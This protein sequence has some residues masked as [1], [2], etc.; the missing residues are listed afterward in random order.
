MVGAEEFPP[1][2]PVPRALEPS[3]VE[4]GEVRR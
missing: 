2:I 1:Y 3:D 4:P